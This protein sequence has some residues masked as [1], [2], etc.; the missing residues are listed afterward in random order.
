MYV[1]CVTLFTVV[2]YVTVHRYTAPPDQRSHH[3]DLY[4]A[5]TSYS[6]VD[7]F[8]SDHN[9]YKQ[10]SWYDMHSNIS[11]SHKSVLCPLPLPQNVA[12]YLSGTDVT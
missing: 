6:I 8:V 1:Q 5:L 7:R 11:S 3:T 10:L 4:I 9:H 12:S 2:L